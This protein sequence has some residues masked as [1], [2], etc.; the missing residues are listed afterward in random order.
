MF[1][2]ISRGINHA[3]AGKKGSKY[4]I[5]ILVEKLD[6]LP[7]AVKKCRVVWSRG[8][9]VQMTEVRDVVKGDVSHS[10]WHTGLLSQPSHC[11]SGC[12][13]FCCIQAA[14]DP[15]SNHVSRCQ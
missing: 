8:P 13:R 12:C 7:A 6:N 5:G 15:D 2:K 14:A 4:K 9:K 1:K 11:D 10:G 3:S